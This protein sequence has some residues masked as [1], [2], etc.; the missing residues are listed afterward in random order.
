MIDFKNINK[1]PRRIVKHTVEEGD[2]YTKSISALEKEEALKEFKDLPD[3]EMII[4]MMGM[5]LC[6]EKGNLLNLTLDQFKSMGDALFADIVRA[7]T[8]SMTGQKKT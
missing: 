3:D 6:D 5:V 1:I 4:K 8:Q 2:F 7:V